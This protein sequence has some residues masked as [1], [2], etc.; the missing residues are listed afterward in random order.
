MTTMKNIKMLINFNW[1]Y[2]IFI[3]KY[4][5]HTRYVIDI[6]SN[7]FSKIYNTWW[8]PYTAKTRSEE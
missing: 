8:W 2:F 3:R 4:H 5:I 7:N 6:Q 1:G